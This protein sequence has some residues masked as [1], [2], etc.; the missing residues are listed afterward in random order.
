MPDLPPL[1]LADYVRAVDQLAHGEGDLEARLLGLGLTPQLFEQADEY[2]QAELD[3]EVNEEGR[4]GPLLAEYLRLLEHHHDRHPQSS[5]TLETWLTI[6]RGV[7]TGEELTSLL[8]LHELSVEEFCRCQRDMT[9]RLA[10]DPKLARR[11]SEL[12]S[13]RTRLERP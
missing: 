8:R 13:G 2:W 4:P 12:L 6:L 1:S 10:Q 3:G 9:R 11:V 7:A 5:V